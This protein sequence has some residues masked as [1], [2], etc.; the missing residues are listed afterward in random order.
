MPA[1]TDRNLLFGI[2]ALQMDFISREQLITGMHAWVLAKEKPLALHLVQACAIS[3]EHCELLE[4]LVEAHIRKHDNDPA[5]SLASL[6]SVGSVKQDL[7]DVGDADLAA[8][9]AQVSAACA[10]E[11]DPNATA[12]WSVGAS[13]S[14]GE[15]FRILRPHA[16]GGLGKV[17]VARDKNCTGK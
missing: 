15:R 10:L 1:V 8:S 4:P 6:I 3:A 13:T 16:Q 7:K 2:L 17:S 11:V 9:V 14:Q 12:N 5:K